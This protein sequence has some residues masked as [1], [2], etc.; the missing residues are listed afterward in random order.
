MLYRA[1]GSTDLRVSVIT[2]GLMVR[3]CTAGAGFDSVRATLLRAVELGINSIDLAIGYGGG[4]VERT[5]GRILANDLP[6]RRDELVI[7]SKGGW[8]DGSRRTLTEHMN[9]ALQQIGTDYVDVFYHHAP[10]DGTPLAGTAGVLDGF[11][12]QGKTRFAGISNYSPEQTAAM[13]REFAA[14]GTPVALHQPNYHMLNRWVEDGLLALLPSL[15]LSAAVFSPLAQGLL[16]D[17]AL[18]RPREG[19]RAS[20]TL[21][22]IVSGAAVGEPAYGVLPRENVESH[23]LRLLG[24]LQAIARE[25]G[26]S[27]SQLALAWVLRDRAVATAVTGA[28]SVAQ[29]ESNAAAA[30]AV[31]LN[32]DV[33]GRIEALLPARPGG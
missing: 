6:G 3:D 1:C 14:L 18:P 25:L 27:L 8:A 29:V 26:V 2:L 22:A 7:A 21:G 24:E 10:D 23:V 9:R 15:G 30:S 13:M 19:S 4:A 5:V 12:K 28:S 11:V 32:D 31:P 16:S 17:R 20:K 33:I